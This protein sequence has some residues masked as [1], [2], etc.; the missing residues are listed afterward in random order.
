MELTVEVPGAP[1]FELDRQYAF[2]YETM[3][4]RPC[5]DAAR[6]G[7]VRSLG[8]ELDGPGSFR[9]AANDAPR[10]GGVV[11]RIARSW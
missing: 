2:L 4:P 9:G 5:R 6:C 1:E 8:G 11:S 10:C 7:C 3:Q